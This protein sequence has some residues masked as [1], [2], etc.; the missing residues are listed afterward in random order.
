MRSRSVFRLS[1]AH[2]C[3]MQPSSIPSSRTLVHCIFISSITAK[4]SAK[5]LATA[6]ICPA[7]HRPSAI[8][9]SDQLRQLGPTELSLTS[10]FRIATA[11]LRDSL[12]SLF[13]IERPT[14]ITRDSSAWRSKTCA[15]K[16]VLRAS[17]LAVTFLPSSPSHFENSSVPR[18]LLAS[19]AQGPLRTKSDYSSLQAPHQSPSKH[20]QMEDADNDFDFLLQLA[21]ATADDEAPMRPGAPLFEDDEAR[22][23]KKSYGEEG[24]RQA[25]PA[26][27]PSQAKPPTQGTQV[28]RAILLQHEAMPNSLPGQGRGPS[29]AKPNVQPQAHA[30]GRA[31]L[32]ASAAA[33][34]QPRSLGSMGPSRI[35]EPLA[36]GYVEEMSK[37]RP[38]SESVVSQPVLG[39]YVVRDRLS[40]NGVFLKLEQLEGMSE[41]PSGNWTTV[42]IVASKVQAESKDGSFY[43]RWQMTDFNS[44]STLFL[45]RNA[46]KDHYSQ[47]KDTTVRG[48]VV[49]LILH[50]PTFKK[51]RG[52][53]TLSVKEPNQIERIGHSPDFTLCKGTL[54]K[55]GAPCT[56]PV[57]KSVCDYCIFHAQVHGKELASVALSISA[58]LQKSKEERAATTNIRSQSQVARPGEGPRGAAAN[59]GG[60]R[61]SQALSAGSGAG[62]SGG[63]VL[64]TAG[65]R[66][67]GVELVM[68]QA[69][70]EEEAAEKEREKAKREGPPKKPKPVSKR[71]LA[72]RAQEVEDSAA[73]RRENC[74]VASDAIAANKVGAAGS[75]TI[76]R[77][78]HELEAQTKLAASLA[79][80]RQKGGPTQ[81]VGSTGRLSQASQLSRRSSRDGGE[82]ETEINEMKARLLALMKERN[83]AGAAHASQTPPTPV[84]APSSK[85]KV[86]RPAR[87]EELI[88]GAAEKG[89]PGAQPVEYEDEDLDIVPDQADVEMNGE[90]Q[91]EVHGEVLDSRDGSKE[92]CPSQGG[93]WSAEAGR[94]VE[95]GSGNTRSSQSERGAG[96]GTTGPSQTDRGGGSGNTRP[97]QSGRGAGSGT[98]GASPTGGCEDEDEG[99]DL[100]I[101]PDEG[102]AEKVGGGSSSSP[103]GVSGRGGG[104]EEDEGSDLDIVPDEGAA[105]KVGGGSSS[106]PQGVSGRG[107]GEEED[108][109]SD[110]DIVPGEGAAEKVGGGSR[111]S[112]PGVSGGLEEDEGSDLD[113]VYDDCGAVADQETGAAEE[114]PAEASGKL[115]GIKRSGAGVSSEADKDQPPLKSSRTFRD[116]TNTAHAPAGPLSSTS[117]AANSQRQPTGQ[118]Q[119][120]TGTIGGGTAGVRPALGLGKVLP[121][122][123]GVQAGSNSVAAKQAA[124]NATKQK[125]VMM[126]DLKLPGRRTT[127]TAGLQPLSRYENQPVNPASRQAAPHGGRPGFV[128]GQGPGQGQVRRTQQMAAPGPVSDMAKMFGALVGTTRVDTVESRY[129]SLA[130]DSEFDGMRKMM[131]EMEKKDQLVQK[132]DSVTK[133]EVLAWHCKESERFSGYPAA[134]CKRNQHAASKV[135][136]WHCKESER[137]S[138]Y[139]AAECKRNQHAASKVLAW[140][141]KESERFSEYPDAECKRNQ[142]TA[143]KECERFSEYPDAECKRNQHAASKV[144]TIKRFWNCGHCN[145]HF[146]TLG[147]IFP[148]KRCPRCND[149]GQV[150]TSATMYRGSKKGPANSSLAERG[151]MKARGTE[152]GF[153]VFSGT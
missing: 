23:L 77:R 21:D 94:K 136:A 117:Y 87:L 104:E 121:K 48:S 64:A 76:S 8:G 50:N 58:Q 115:T 85:D 144:K 36:G 80:Q 131:E 150:F 45:W 90:P 62:T 19:C 110:L 109:G 59:V 134:E 133:L 30:N 25:P 125:G 95:G 102:A 61:G 6:T 141:C 116:A 120:S 65:K 86:V 122:E 111:S 34:T 107:G 29:Q 92:A 47:H 119:G 18:S 11:S 26:A 127:A 63:G 5:T 37:L 114:K 97:S 41:A 146:S 49:W 28:G 3:S 108:E 22:E 135:L 152:H 143:S 20:F 66:S 137:F 14:C 31:S 54:K 53:V 57:N 4:P 103:Q 129:S 88:Q 106:S 140:H 70:T 100:D 139:P 113:I 10:I 42:A 33:P 149:P 24:L 99:S 151:N 56:T 142:H 98:T 39:S 123:Y 82:L 126:K 17:Q 101:V 145:G 130:E 74:K 51:E 1:S 93:G 67:R 84:P 132:L 2:T 69:K 43:S 15:S 52:K 7:V 105:E 128:K 83:Q 81:A 75:G 79:L 60:P 148:K 72:E 12:T 73:L 118:P 153:G 78:N 138:G 35:S 91:G 68:A 124:S 96:S 27:R 40:N 55:D 9:L 147:L 44:T 16:L 112:P 46:L 38:P 71:G 32:S 89:G 13:R